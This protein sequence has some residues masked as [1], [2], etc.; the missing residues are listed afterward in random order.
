[1]FGAL[2]YAS[3]LVIAHVYIVLTEQL[4]VTDMWTVSMTLYHCL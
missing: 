3:G 1:M 4:F 2:S